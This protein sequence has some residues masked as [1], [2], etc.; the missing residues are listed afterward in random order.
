MKKFFVFFVL[1]SG[2]SFASMAQQGNM[3]PAQRKERELKSLKEANLGLTD[4][5]A[6]SVVSINTEAMQ[7][8]RGFRD[9]SQDERIAKMKE[10]NDYRKKRW[11]EVLKNDDLVNKVA[12]YYQQRQQRRMQGRGGGGGQ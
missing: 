5:Q 7:Q 6:D 10:A 8:M 9:L 11:A 2:L 3:D 12:D 4:A 1:F